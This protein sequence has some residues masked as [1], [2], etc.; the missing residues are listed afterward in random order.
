MSILY[1]INLAN[2]TSNSQMLS[3]LRVLHSTRVVHNDIKE[4]NWVLA[5][6]DSSSAMLQ[7]SQEPSD[8]GGLCPHTVKI[9]IIDFGLAK[10]TA[11]AGCGGSGAE[12][13]GTYGARPNL[14]HDDAFA[15]AVCVVMDIRL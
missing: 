6:V 3:V 4:D 14:R 5:S 12:E 15:T 2:A 8:C 11:E 7:C 1:N 9:C 13:V 10:M